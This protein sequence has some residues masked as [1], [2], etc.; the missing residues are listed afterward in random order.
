MATLIGDRRMF[1]AALFLI[2]GSV[3]GVP[4]FVDNSDELSQETAEIINALI[5][6]VNNLLAFIVMIISYTKRPP[7]GLNYKQPNIEEAVE[8][9]VANALKNITK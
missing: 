2:I 4:N 9:A 6:A 5:F 3:F 8:R 7:S 1:I